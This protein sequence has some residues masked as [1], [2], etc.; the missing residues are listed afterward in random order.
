MGQSR[1][2]VSRSTQLDECVTGLHEDEVPSTPVSPPPHIPLKIEH[3]RYLG[4]VFVCGVADSLGITEQDRNK[5]SYSFYPVDYSYKYFNNAPIHKIVCGLNSSFFI[6][7]NG[8]YACGG[9]KEGELGL[10]YS[11]ETTI[12]TPTRV[13]LSATIHDIVTGT[14]QYTIF[15][16]SNGELLH[17][18]YRLDFTYERNIQ[19]KALPPVPLANYKKIIG[20]DSFVLVLTLGGQVYGLGHVDGYKL[21][22]DHF[23]KIEHSLLKE[24]IIDIGCGQRHIILITGNRFQQY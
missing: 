10:G 24:P 15:V 1:S 22:L 16:M 5:K 23:V 7:N 18:G 21:A 2:S 14:R 11:S 12:K 9:N 3:N 20:G 4:A 13:P 17:C 6:T 19:P 8:V